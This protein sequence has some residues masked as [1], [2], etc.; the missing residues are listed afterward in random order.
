MLDLLRHGATL[1]R[2]KLRDSLG[3]KNERS[4]EALE[5][6]ERAGRLCRHPLVGNA[7]MDRLKGIVPVPHK[8]LGG[9]GTVFWSTERQTVYAQKNP[10]KNCKSDLDRMIRSDFEH[11]MVRAL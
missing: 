9:N 2:A 6:L 4:G 5:A 3:V 7:A 8:E 1:T 11:Q 10:Q